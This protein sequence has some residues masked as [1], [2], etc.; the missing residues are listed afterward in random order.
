MY[1]LHYWNN[2]RDCGYVHESDDLDE[3]RAEMNELRKRDEDCARSIKDYYA[4]MWIEDSDM[5]DVEPI[6]YV[7]G[8]DMTILENRIA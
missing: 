4:Q 6:Q 5:N 2:Y 3:L 8:E 1:E 7:V